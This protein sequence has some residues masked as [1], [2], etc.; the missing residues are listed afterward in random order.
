MASETVGI[1][2]VY[3]FHEGETELGYLQ[4]LAKGRGSV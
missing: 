2:V 4:S 1:P 3:L